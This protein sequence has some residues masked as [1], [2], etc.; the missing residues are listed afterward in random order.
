MRYSLLFG[1][2]RKN[3]PKFDSK[4]ATLLIKAGLIDQTMSG[5]Y[6]LLPLGLRVL[7]KIENIVREEMDKIAQEM[8]LTALSPIDF[9]KRTSRH[10]IDV[11]FEAHGICLKDYHKQKKYFL[12]L[13]HEDNITP[14]IKHFAKSY[15]DFPI[16]LYQIQTKFRNE[17]RAKSGLLRCREFIMKDLYSFHVSEDDLMQYYAKVKQAYLNIFNKIGIGNLTYVALASGGDFT[18]NYS[19]EFQVRCLTGEDTVFLSSNGKCYNKEIAPSKAPPTEPDKNIFKMQKVYTPNI[20]TAKDLAQFLN[21]PLEKCVKTIIYKAD[22]KYYGVALRGD[23][24]INE[25]KLKKILKAKNIRLAN[26]EEIIT[27]TNAQVGYAGLINLNPNIQVICDESIASLVNFECGANETNYHY[28]N[29]NWDIDLPRPS[30]FYDIKIA[31]E[32][33]LDPNTNQPYEVFKAVE[34]GNIFPLGIKFSRD[35]DLKFTDES[36]QEHYPYMGS[37]GIGITRLIGVIAEV[38]SD[39]KGLVWP[40]NIAPYKYHLISLAKDENDRVHQRSLEIYQQM[41]DLKQEVLWDDRLDAT[42]GEKLKD[43]DLIGIPYRIVISPTTLAQES[44]EVK[45]R[46]Q[47]VSN[48][49]SIPNF[50]GS[51]S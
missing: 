16:A 28:V 17:E 14:M 31:K 9:Y 21:M 20:T 51:F 27:L 3:T 29:V 5:V 8:L 13:T 7:R 23:Y 44:V 40:E 41:I 36:G 50:L 6:K 43:A 46:T 2:T 25:I 26:D 34:V 22:D 32:G 18:E 48:L 15:K 37:Y 1:K 45:L 38:L 39:E 33:D 11:L 47:N 42:A 24:E 35:F 49:V 10:N 19:E 4:N 30:N 12:N